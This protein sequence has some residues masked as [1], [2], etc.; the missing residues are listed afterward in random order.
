MDAPASEFENKGR[1]V[2]LA[3]LEAVILELEQKGKEFQRKLDKKKQKRENQKNVVN[4]S[5]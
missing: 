2:G 1:S 4:A 3:R 5:I